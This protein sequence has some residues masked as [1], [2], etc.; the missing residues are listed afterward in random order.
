[1]R[2]ANTVFRVGLFELD[3][4]LKNTIGTGVGYILFK[5]LNKKLEK[6]GSFNADD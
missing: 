1:M 3:D 2:Y 6:E 4:L 5:I